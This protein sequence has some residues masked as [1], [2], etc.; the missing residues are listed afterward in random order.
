MDG[1]KLAMHKDTEVTRTDVR[2]LVCM[3]RE[4]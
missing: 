2:D 4:A 3:C 1:S